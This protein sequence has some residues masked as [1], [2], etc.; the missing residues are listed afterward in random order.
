MLMVTMFINQAVS[1]TLYPDMFQCSV[2]SS[3]CI[4]Q[5]VYLSCMGAV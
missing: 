1:R 3:Y 5:N 4:H 2:I